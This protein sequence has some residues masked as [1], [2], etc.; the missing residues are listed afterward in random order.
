MNKIM[1]IAARNLLRYQ[2]RT[3]LTSMLIVI[4]VVAV[5]LFVAITGSGL[6]QGKRALQERLLENADIPGAGTLFFIATAGGIVLPAI[7]IVAWFQA[8]IAPRHAQGRGQFGGKAIR[9]RPLSAGQM[10]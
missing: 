1:E 5:L 3:L 2:R 9:S 7:A 6:F 8:N 4:G 10:P